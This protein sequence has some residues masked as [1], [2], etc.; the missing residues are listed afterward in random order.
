LPYSLFYIKDPRHCVEDVFPFEMRFDCVIR[1][2]A[3]PL[4]MNV[5]ALMSSNL[6]AH[7][8]FAGAETVNGAG[9]ISAWRSVQRRR[10]RA[11]TEIGDLT[12]LY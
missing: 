4:S 2:A 6:D 9:W 5:I 11:P 7:P 12:P 1:S 8:P 10:G 3:E